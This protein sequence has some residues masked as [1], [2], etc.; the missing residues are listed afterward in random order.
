MDFA[1]LGL[2]EN[3]VKAVNEAGYTAPTSVQQAAIPAALAGKDLVVS[4]QTGSGKTAAFMLPSLERLTTEPTIKARGP[5]VLV[6]TPT[7]ELAVQV[8]EA[9]KR[10]GKNLRYAKAVSVVGGMP[11]PVQNKLLSS[12]YEILVATPGR[13]MDQMNSGRIDFARLEILILDEADRML[14]MGFVDDIEA[15]CAR[16]PANRQT[17]FFSA[18]L[19]GQVARM[20]QRLLKDPERIEIDSAQTRHENIEQRLMVADDI[21]HKNR[22]LDGLLRDVGVD[23]AIVF[24]ATKRDADALTL[25]LESMGHSVA[26]L[27]GDMNQRMRTRTLDQLRRGHLRV[28]IATDVAARGIDVR[29]IS[30]V[31]NYD[32]PKVAADY[33]HRIG[34]TGRGGSSGIAIS[35]AERRDVRLLRAIERYTRQPLAVHT[36]PGLEPRSTMPADDRRPGGPR[37]EGGRSF[38]NAPRF[39]D[40]R[41]SAGHGGAR[42]GDKPAGGFGGGR[43]D[44]NERRDDTRGDSRPA[45]PWAGRSEGTRDFG[46]NRRTEFADRPRH[47]EHRTEFPHVA[48]RSSTHHNAGSGFGGGRSGDGGKPRAG[49]TF[50]RDR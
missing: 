10:Y 28:L 43:F 42:F 47:P 44:R 40:K 21:G 4:S 18:T 50:N 27:H 46:D 23:Q 38:G 34:R 6:L 36:L 13:L 26:A 12:P 37:R 8:T 22:L 19:D 29:T 49:R 33:V 48:K 32:L 41:P 16:L 9:T 31:I 25:N 45:S 14:D 11:Y 2:S 7:R 3:I 5:R 39:G 15:I 1:S 24:T 20:M 17:L 35:L 30:H